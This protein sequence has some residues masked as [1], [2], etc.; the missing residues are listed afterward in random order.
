M[1]W[2]PRLALLLV[3]KNITGSGRWARKYYDARGYDIHPTAYIS[4][5]YLDVVHPEK[6]HIQ[7]GATIGQDAM[8]ITHGPGVHNDVVIERNAYVGAGAIVLGCRVGEGA[9]V[10]AG[11]VVRKDVKPWAIIK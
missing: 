7:A 8:L 3:M 11:C 2:T 9:V 10:G 1:R 4:M 5:C 6:I